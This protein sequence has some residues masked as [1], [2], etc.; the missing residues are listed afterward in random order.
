MDEEGEPDYE[1]F[2]YVDEHSCIGCTMC[3]GVAPSTFFMED[4]HGRA[5]VFRQQG[6]ADETIAE[7]IATCPVNCIHYVP[8]A[9]LAK[10]ETRRRGQV[11]NNAGRL[12]S[13][14]EGKGVGTSHLVSGPLGRYAAMARISTRDRRPFFGARA[15]ETVF[16]LFLLLFLSSCVASYRRGACVAGGNAKIRCGNCPSNGCADCPMY[17]AGENPVF[18]DRAKAKE[19]KRRDRIRREIQAETGTASGSVE[20]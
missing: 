2:T 16:L 20:L 11:I 1:R 13:Q 12:V 8:F 3:A 4:A 10:L 6:D 14:A 5:R 7:A 15:R 9:E 19:V 18:V 17:G